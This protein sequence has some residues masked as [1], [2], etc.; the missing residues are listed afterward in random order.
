MESGLKHKLWKADISAPDSVIGEPSGMR[1][2]F[3]SHLRKGD[4]NPN[5][6]WIEVSKSLM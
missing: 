1:Y 5:I 4:M 2:D 3:I 6:N